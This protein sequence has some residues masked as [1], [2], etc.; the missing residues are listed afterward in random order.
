MSARR[1]ES[2]A[3]LSPHFLQEARPLLAYSARYSFSAGSAIAAAPAP[4]AAAP[5]RAARPPPPRPR[6]L[7][8]SAE[9]APR[10]AGRAHPPLVHR[11]RKPGGSSCV[12]M[13]GGRGGAAR[14]AP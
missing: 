5:P 4:A 7:Q 2:L 9:R 14:A 13:G 1:S 6:Q 3:M 8:P 11:L 12:S 10:L